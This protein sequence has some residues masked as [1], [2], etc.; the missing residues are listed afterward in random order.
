MSAEKGIPFQ[1]FALAFLFFPLMQTKQGIP[2]WVWVILI[3]ILIILVYLVLRGGRKS[4]PAAIQESIGLEEEPAAADD[5]TTIE[6]IGPKISQLL[7]DAGYHTYSQL[8]EA[9]M[10]QI[11]RLLTEANLRLANPATWGEQARLAA[12]GDWA[13]LEKL[14]NELKGGRR[15]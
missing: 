7:Q 14:Q 12:A 3:I 13:A 6:G 5:L 8:A 15:E 2:W 11:D 10:S 1:G 4:T 9:D